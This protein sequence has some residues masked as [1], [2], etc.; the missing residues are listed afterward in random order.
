[1]AT[2]R[3]VPRRREAD[4]AGADD[5]GFNVVAICHR[6]LYPHRPGNEEASI[7]FLKKRHKKLFPL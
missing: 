6:E 3:Q 7:S 4:R 2:L 5:Y 1:M